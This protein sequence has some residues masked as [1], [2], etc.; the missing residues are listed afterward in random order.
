M[1]ART[2]ITTMETRSARRMRFMVAYGAMNPLDNSVW[3][4][5]RGPQRRFAQGDGLAV[6]FDPEV[7]VFAALPDV[8]TPAAWEA[9]RELVGRGQL[10]VLFRDAVVAPAGWQEL[11]RMPTLQMVAPRS[12]SA[13][14]G[15]I[16]PLTKADVE[17]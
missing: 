2:A 1:A 11:F 12:D 14:D 17:E 9:L 16:A 6:R 15:R 8:P 13:R 10:A 3:H 4:A 5:L 7:S